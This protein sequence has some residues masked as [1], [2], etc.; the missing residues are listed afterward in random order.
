[1]KKIIRNILVISL[2]SFLVFFGLVRLYF[3][4]N[5]YI[6]DE[7]LKSGLTVYRASELPLHPLDL[8]GQIGRYAGLLTFYMPSQVTIGEVFVTTWTNEE[9][10]NANDYF[11]IN[12]YPCDDGK[13]CYLN[14]TIKDKTA[15]KYTTYSGIVGCTA[16][17]QFSISPEI[18]VGDYPISYG[19]YCYSSGFGW[20][21]QT[22]GSSTI[23]AIDSQPVCGDGRCTRPYEC[24]KGETCSNP[25][26]SDCGEVL[27]I[28]GNG[29][30]ESS[31]GE[32]CNTCQI[33]CGVCPSNCE[34][35][36]HH[37]ICIGKDRYWSDACGKANDFIASCTYGCNDGICVQC[38]P[39]NYRACSGNNLCWYDSCGNMGTCT[40]CG[41]NEQC[42]NGACIPITVCTD[43][44]TWTGTKC[45]DIDKDGVNEIVP[46]GNYDSD[47]CKDFGTPI[48]CGTGTVCG[49]TPQ[50]ATC[51]STCTDECYTAGYSCEGNNV[52]YCSATLDT[53]SCLDKKI[54]DTCESDETCINN[55]CVKTQLTCTNECIPDKYPSCNEQG[56]V[57]QCTDIDNDGCTE[58]WIMN[59]EKGYVCLSG[60]CNKLGGG[61]PDYVCGNGVCEAWFGE[62]LSNCL[63]DCSRGVKP[64]QTDYT[65]HII[66]GALAGLSII[67]LIKKKK[68]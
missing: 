22:G 38:Y 15:Q 30:C 59:C 61:E 49:D 2:I 48:K 58:L 40:P 43:D 62:T 4:Y 11:H 31:L 18:G 51:T 7:Y 56:S 64:R 60:E 21:K 19:V 47:P 65:P 26:K 53:D 32:T 3:A 25:C 68:K 17:L 20:S 8:F 24:S 12:N 57:N 35:L 1:M 63:Q 44:C 14:V 41:T 16:S 67:I 33:D 34:P 54:V 39:N 42:S 46:C 52:V 45:Y 55:N 66:I 23:K 27:S 5:I 9:W 28:C 13:T 36:H 29:R 37:Y 6:P 10:H 50:G